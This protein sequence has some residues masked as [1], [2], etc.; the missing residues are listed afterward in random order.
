MILS[1]SI[2]AVRSLISLGAMPFLFIVHLL[3]VSLV[4]SLAAEPLK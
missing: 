1:N 2:D 4:R 3:L